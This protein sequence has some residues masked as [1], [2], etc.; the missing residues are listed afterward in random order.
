M[1]PLRTCFAVSLLLLVLTG[2]G[3][4][5]ELAT[6]YFAFIDRIEDMPGAHY[7]IS[8][9]PEAL[10]CVHLNVAGSSSEHPDLHLRL[11]VLGLYRPGELGR[12]GDRVSFRLVGR[13][14]ASG[15]IWMSQ[16][17]GYRIDAHLKASPATGSAAPHSI[18]DSRKL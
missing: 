4:R 12:A 18:P 14:P 15:E 11:F 17:A 5:T 16:L 2:C 3:H 10:T 7:S 13:L 8:K 1:K 9:G 6:E